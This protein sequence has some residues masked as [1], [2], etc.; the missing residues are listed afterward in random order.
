MVLCSRFERAGNPK[1]VQ[2][3]VYVSSLTKLSHD[4]HYYQINDSNRGVIQSVN[5]IMIF[6]L[7]LLIFARNFL[8]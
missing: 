5:I 2:S 1:Y 3:S 4:A 6:I 7:G 8:F